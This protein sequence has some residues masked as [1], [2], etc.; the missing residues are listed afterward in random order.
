MTVEQPYVPHESFVRKRAEEAVGELKNLEPKAKR[1]TLRLVRN[2]IIGDR[3][4]KFTFVREGAV[5][6]VSQIL[7]DALTNPA[8]LDATTTDL[9]IQSAA[10]LGSFS[11][12]WE[13]GAEAVIES[14]AV[15]DLTTL[16]GSCDSRLVTAAARAMRLLFK[17]SRANA[18]SPLSD[19]AIHLL[20]NLLSLKDELT[21]GVSA[22]ILAKCCEI[23][24]Q[25]DR[26]QSYG[27]LRAIMKLLQS[28]L[29]KVQESSMECLA[30]MTNENKELALA[31][32]LE[33]ETVSTLL[34][35]SKTG[36]PSVKLLACRCITN[37]STQP[38]APEEIEKLRVHLL[39]IVIKLLK[40]LLYAQDPHVPHVLAKLLY[41]KQDLQNVAYDSNA[42]FLLT[43]WLSSLR[44]KE[45][46]DREAKYL[47]EGIL[48]AIGIISQHNEDAR[49]SVIELDG[50]PTIVESLRDEDD[51][52]RAAACL[53]AKSLSRSRKAIKSS[54][55]EAKI[56][57][58]LLSLLSDPS[59]QV[60]QTASATLCNLVLSFMPMKEN[61]LAAGG[62]RE[63]AALSKS[64]DSIL[65][66]HS[67]WAIKNLLYR[68]DRVL[69]E[70]VME[71]LTWP[72][73]LA[74]LNDSEPDVQV[75]AV[76]IVRNL[77][78]GKKED[79]EPVVQYQDG[80]VLSI[81]ERILGPQSG[82]SAEMKKHAVYAVSN[83]CS[84]SNKH[85]DMIM[86]SMILQSILQCLRDQQSCELRVAAAWVVINLTWQ[87]A[88]DEA[89]VRSRQL[90]LTQMGFEAQ[91]ESMLEDS[92]LNVKDRVL[93]ALRGITRGTRR[94]SAV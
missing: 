88:E 90:R 11:C 18:L 25:Q 56:D 13:M 9:V 60:Q 93:A 22:S 4:K 50:I 54:L 43:S 5:Q 67:T 94:G 39:P 68:A 19:A 71:E 7:R 21:A 72:Q 63:L 10:T 53:C 80:E 59:R 28:K 62:V 89:S 83:I 14:G 46:E 20:I 6:A 15:A 42:V 41:D 40:Q 49:R 2:E 76:I 74:L 75:Q 82:S 26:I 73:L 16:L 33:P 65:R 78:F 45:E 29:L 37:I 61:I 51:G 48:T 17:S 91:L 27:G 58:P 92:S 23:H 77:V 36:N 30:A 79:I 87:D 81:L 66:L 86:G 31:V 3:T 85:K 55:F 84:G 1:N 35:L 44:G 47:K 64:P 34:K 8:D 12:G 70:R 32:S 38:D 24:G 52:V 57:A 69:K